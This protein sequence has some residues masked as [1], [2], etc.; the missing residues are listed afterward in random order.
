MGAALSPSRIP[1]FSLS[2]TAA[3][4]SPATSPS[5]TGRDEGAHL[6]QSGIARAE[7]PGHVEEIKY[8]SSKDQRE[9]R[10]GSFFLPILIP[11]KNIL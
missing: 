10:D 1:V 2:P 7:K 4:T 6:T 8:K 11:R 3:R 9:I 5:A